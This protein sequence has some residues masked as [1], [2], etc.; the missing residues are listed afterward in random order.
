MRTMA[1]RFKIGLVLLLAVGAFLGGFI[2]QFLENRRL[3]S[4]IEASRTSLGRFQ[5]QAEVDEIR[6]LAGKTLLQASRQNYGTAAELATQYFNSVQ[7]LMS[8]TDN[9]ALQSALSELLKLRDPIMSALAQANPAVVS[10]LHSL[11]QRS[12]DLPV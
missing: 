12:Y 10:E 8:K 7:S 9:T 1:N 3:R 2:P 6:N 5:I 4:E 11:L